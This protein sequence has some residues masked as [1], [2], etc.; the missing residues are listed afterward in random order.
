M[1]PEEKTLIS[2]L[3][4]RIAQTSSQPK[5]S[6]AEQLIRSKVSENPSA[7]YL[8]AQSTLVLQH[9]LANA[10]SRIADLERQATEAQAQ[11]APKQG[12]FLSG[13]FGGG[14]SS[15]PPVPQR[16]VTQPPPVPYQAGY[17]QQPYQ[18]P[19]PPQQPQYGYPPPQQGA[20]SPMGGFLSGALTTAAGVAGGALLFRGIEGLLG[21]NPGP[22][23]GAAMPGGG[24][25]NPGGST[26]NVTEVTNNY[27]TE[28]DR[29]AE[30]QTVDP[31][32]ADPDPDP[33]PSQ[34]A[35][36]DD[37]ASFDPDPD[38]DQSTDPNDFASDDSGFDDGG[39][40][41]DNFA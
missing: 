2:G 41:D 5:D 26:E 28:G 10:Q 35:S 36:N 14:Q 19:I 27:Y 3:F 21:H 38:P 17:Q 13:L 31:S 34:Y 16:P 24:F 12:G 33:D 18:Q 25:L 11:P 23:A 29:G 6:E 15:P 39:G 40:N 22:F 30:G 4:D 9:A 32:Q 8:L 37:P 20:G 1:T 7:P